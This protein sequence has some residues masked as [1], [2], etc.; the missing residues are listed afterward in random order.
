MKRPTGPVDPIRLEAFRHLFAALP[1][2][3]DSAPARCSYSPNS[4]ER[5]DYSCA[6]FDGRRSKVVAGATGQCTLVPCS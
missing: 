6:L 5:R 2:E 1:E 4:K 3:L